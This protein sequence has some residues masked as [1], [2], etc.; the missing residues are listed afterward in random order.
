MASK[1]FAFHL[2]LLSGNELPFCFKEINVACVNNLNG[3]RALSL[4][5]WI[6]MIHNNFLN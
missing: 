1:D 2:S 4:I 3:A 5:V 6:S